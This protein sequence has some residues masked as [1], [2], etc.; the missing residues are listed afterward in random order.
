MGH[1][2]NGKLLLDDLARRNSRDIG[3]LVEWPILSRNGKPQPPRASDV[4]YVTEGSSRGLLRALV[5]QNR[6]E[7]CV[8]DKRISDN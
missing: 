5:T 3:R 1:A 2:E 8:A 6:A 7:K 4:Q